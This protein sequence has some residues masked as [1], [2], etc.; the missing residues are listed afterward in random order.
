MTVEELFGTSFSK[1]PPAVPYSNPERTEKSQNDALCK[2]HNFL[3]PFSFEQSTVIH[4]PLGKLDGPGF[5]NSSCTLLQQECVSPLLIAPPPV[6][7]AEINKVSNYTVQLSPVLNSASAGETPSVQIL[8]SLHTNNNIIQVMQQAT[9][10]VSLL[11]SQ[12]PSD[13]NHDPQNLTPSQN[14]FITSLAA[15]NTEASNVTLSNVDLLHKLRLT[16]QHEQ[17]QQSHSKTPV[18]PNFSSAVN[19][20]ATPDCFKESHIKQQALTGKMLP[21]IQV[22]CGLKYSKSANAVTN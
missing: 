10:Q 9:K 17:M 3:L 21:P 20:L 18:A 1:D 11:G 4:Q 22:G 16:P 6:S 14:H 7:Q 8:Q 12:P 5:R 2:E 19:Q 13:T 15:A